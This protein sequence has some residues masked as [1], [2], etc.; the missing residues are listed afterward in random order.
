MSN[1]SGIFSSSITPN[2]ITDIP[3]TRGIYVGSGGDL[4]VKMGYGSIVTFT[5]IAPGMIHP[6]S[7]TRIYENGTTASGIVAVY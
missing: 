3:T 7:A 5:A 6:I 1:G 4:K 2:D